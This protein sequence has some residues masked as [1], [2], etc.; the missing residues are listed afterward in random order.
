M[1][2]HEPSPNLIP[3]PWWLPRSVVH[4]VGVIAANMIETDEQQAILT[5]LTTDI[6]MRSVWRQLV[7]RDRNTGEFHFAA[8]RPPGWDDLADD[9]VSLVV[10]VRAFE[11]LLF[12]AF[13]VARDQVRVSTPEEADAVRHDTIAQSKGPRE[14]AALLRQK[15]IQGSQAAADADALDRAADWLEAAA[16]EVRPPTDPLF[17]RRHRGD[18]VVRGVSIVVGNYLMDRF[19]SRLDGIAATIA[20]VALGKPATARAVRSAFSQPE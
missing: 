1:S 5:R 17:V 3:L 14:L 19:G 12:C 9:N 7:R 16:K 15:C 11:E 20:S 10:Q 8:K 2:L 6:R 13:C 18:P 4:G